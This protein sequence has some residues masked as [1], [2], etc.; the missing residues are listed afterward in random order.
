MNAPIVALTANNLLIL[1]LTALSLTM[2]AQTLFA[3]LQ[4][5]TRTTTLPHALWQVSTSCAISKKK[6]ELSVLLK[7]R[8]WGTR[9]N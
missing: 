2:L 1:P 8:T 5:I 9:K 7:M 3:T 6:I 4:T